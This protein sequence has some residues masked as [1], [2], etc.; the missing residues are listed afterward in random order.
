M[1][2]KAPLGWVVSFWTSE[3]GGEGEG[4]GVWSWAGRHEPEEHFG[5]EP[6][7][8]RF[9]WHGFLYVTGC[10]TPVVC[11]PLGRSRWK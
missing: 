11:G 7:V 2:M 9:G 1:L 10:S 3:Q 4:G 6:P 5:V 8:G